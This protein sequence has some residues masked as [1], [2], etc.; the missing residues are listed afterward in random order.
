M[1]KTQ[2]IR[3]AVKASGTFLE[4]MRRH[5]VMRNT[6]A[7]RTKKPYANAPDTHY[8]L[9]D[10]AI[11]E[12]K[13]FFFGQ[14]AA[15]KRVCDF[16]AR[17]AEGAGYKAQLEEWFDYQVKERSEF[18]SR[19]LAAV[20]AM[21]LHGRGVM[22]VRWDEGEGALAFDAVSPFHIIMA[23][24]A[25]GFE[26]ADWFVHVKEFTEGRFFRDA[27]YAATH[28]TGEMLRKLVGAGSGDG[29]SEQAK[30]ER[31]EREGVTRSAEGNIVV[32]EVWEQVAGG[33]HVTE[34]SPALDGLVLRAERPSPFQWRGKTIQPFASLLFEVED[35]GWFAPRGIGERLEH[36]EAALQM[37]WNAKL[38]A[39]QFSGTPLFKSGALTP[40]NTAGVTFVPGSMLPRDVEPV[41]MPSPP[42]AFDQ[43]MQVTRM[44]AEQLVRL[45]KAG[46]SPDA[47]KGGNGKEVTARQVSYQATLAD[48]STNLRGYVFR[49]GLAKVFQK[50]W[51]ILSQN[52]KEQLGY[53][54]GDDAR[55]LPADA[56][57]AE[58][59]LRPS[60][61]VDDWNRQAATERAIG[62]MQLFNGDP[63]INQ[64]E[65]RRDVL[66][67]ENPALV[68]RLLLPQGQK[69]ASEAED[70]A[71]EVLVLMSGYPAVVKPGEDHATRIGVLMGKLQQLEATGEPVDPIGRQ[72][73]QE[74]LAVHVQMLQQEDAQKGAKVM[75]SI[76]AALNPAPMPPVNLEPSARPPGETPHLA[77]A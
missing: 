11:G 66:A 74:H 60:G 64:E 18:S 69:E 32:W 58:M 6:G 52:G 2:T 5:Y 55:Q 25:N 61:A 29:E 51:A 53:L 72:R 47:S 20:D 22:K 50:A 10:S 40:T 39:L 77:V 16:V 9:I 48:A 8:P 46:L 23:P 26:D 41:Q 73:L 33:W 37:A 21:L 3:D 7:K 34:I 63:L 62:R 43:D 45:P 65:L 1:I 28:K 27:R 30:E 4:K 38:T 42:V 68:A 31:F 15:G 71:M 76:D 13:P 57:A 70:E 75:A 67:S 17:K 44:V 49:L 59:D 24:G 35:E 54:A 12:L 19:M 36:F 14:L 56:L